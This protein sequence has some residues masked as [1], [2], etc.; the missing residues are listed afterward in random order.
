MLRIDE[1]VSKNQEEKM[2]AKRARWKWSKNDEDESMQK[3]LENLL[4]IIMKYVLKIKDT[5]YFR[6]W[7]LRECVIGR[8]ERWR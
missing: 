4:P 6:N 8:G 2:A 5:K 7:W 3:M 1:D